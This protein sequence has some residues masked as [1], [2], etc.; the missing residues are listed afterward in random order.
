MKVL[1]VFGKYQYG[2][3]NR[4]IGTEYGSFVP[5]LQRL[6]HEVVHFDS[7][8][9]SC[10]RSF[11]EL[12]IALLDVVERERPHILLAVQMHYE[13]WIE[14][15]KIIKNR[16]DVITLCWTTDDSWKYKE[17]SRFIGHIYHVMTTTYPEVVKNYLRDGIHN[18]LLTQWASIPGNL[19]RPRPASKCTYLVS[20]IGAAHGNRKKQISF[21]RASGIDVTCFGHGWPAGPIEFNRIPEIMNES[22]INLNFANSRGLN[23]IK[24]RIFEVL[25]A[26]GFL[27]TESAPGIERYYL[28]DKEIVIFNGVR[29]LVEKIK[30]FLSHLDQRDQIAIAGFLRTEKDHTY[31]IRM[32]DI[33]DFALNSREILAQR[34]L[35]NPQLSLEEVLRKHKITFALKI[36]RLTLVLP[37]KMIWGKRR[38]PRVAR[39]LL[40]ELSCRL[41]GAKTYTSGGWVGRIFYNES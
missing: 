41:V 4:G 38:G 3:S 23:Q 16:G 12:N 24:A 34:N 14:T 7:W 5:A 25:G 35:Q 1:C 28:P 18:V 9:R 20:F 2:D 22:I 39:R 40:F 6:G 10:Y 37:C 8:D 26:G 31:D 33:L 15:L 21:L 27:L 17:C 29:D 19:F 13:I 11:A 36:L 32:R 30:Y